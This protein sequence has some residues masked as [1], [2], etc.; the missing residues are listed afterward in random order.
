MD[1]AAAPKQANAPAKLA[2]FNASAGS[3]KAAQK[4]NV[5]ISTMRLVPYLLVSQPV[6][7]MEIKEPSAIA[8]KAVPSLAGVRCSAF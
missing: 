8:I 2:R 3:G 6:S 5:E 7:G 4:A 1:P